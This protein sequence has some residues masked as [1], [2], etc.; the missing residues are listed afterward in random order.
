MQLLYQGT[1]IGWVTLRLINNLFVCG[2]EEDVDAEK[3]IA[4]KETL[5]K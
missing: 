3:G 4:E 5:R 2:D 1:Q